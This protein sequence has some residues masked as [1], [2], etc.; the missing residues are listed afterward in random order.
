MR[1]NEILEFKSD[2]TFYGLIDELWSEAKNKWRGADYETRCAVW[3]R[4]KEWCE[5]GSEL[6]SITQ[7]NDIIWFECDDLFYP[8]SFT[9]E[10]WEYDSETGSIGEKLDNL[11]VPF[12]GLRA[13]EHA[14]EFAKSLNNE[15]RR[16][17]VTNDETGEVTD[18]Y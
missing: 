17:T 16:I 13:R 1:D 3:D 7:I 15:N 8:P 10:V 5:C 14:V 4:V 9:V 6:P 11:T 2:C 12:D 18:D